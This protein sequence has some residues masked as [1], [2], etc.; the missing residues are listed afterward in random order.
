MFFNFIVKK[1]LIIQTAFIGDVVLATPVAEKLHQAIPDAS[2]DFL[3]RKGCEDLFENHPFINNILIWD[4][5]KNKYKNL[6]KI[7]KQVRK[8]K[9]DLLINIYRFGSSGIITVFSNATITIGFDKNPFSIFFSKRIKHIF[10]KKDNMIHEIDRNLLL[11][12]EYGDKSR[13]MP[14][15]YPSDNDYKK[16]E[17]DREKE[18]ICIS[19]ASIWFTKQFPKEKWIEIIKKIP[20]PLQIFFIGSASDKVLCSEIITESDNKNSINFAGELTLLET[21]AIMKNAKMNFVNDSASMHIASAI[22]APVT[23]IYCS[24]VPF[25]GFW[26][27]SLNSHIIETEK[28][29]DCRPCGIHGLRSCPENH[30][31]CAFTISSDKILNTIT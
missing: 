5:K 6:F 21:A 16:T 14:R 25:F 11:I 2:I 7:I 26:P 17:D 9:Y 23:A 30:F 12:S 15:I 18:Y 20:E 3:L 19:P 10:G 27:L 1:I 28:K 4:K 24:T 13:T 8:N 22:N 29:L 31:E